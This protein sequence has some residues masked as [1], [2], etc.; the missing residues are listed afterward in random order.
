M[1]PRLAH[2]ARCKRHLWASCSWQPSWGPAAPNLSL[3]QS[4]LPL[5]RIA[6]TGLER[7]ATYLQS[8]ETES[9][10]KVGMRVLRV[11]QHN[12]REVLH[13]LL[14]VVNHLISLCTL[15]HVPNVIGVPLNTPTIRPNRFF[16]LLH[17]AIRQTNVV[18]NVSFNWHVWFVFKSLLKLFDTLLVLLV[19]VVGQT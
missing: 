14:V 11:L 7:E 2:T 6:K 17:P 15:M 8:F 1:V 19:R 5:Q 18:V 12:N 9:S 16:E 10:P 13:C 3:S 4:H